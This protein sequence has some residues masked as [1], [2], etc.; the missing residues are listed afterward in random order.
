[1]LI[2]NLCFHSKFTLNKIKVLSLINTLVSKYTLSSSYF[3]FQTECNHNGIILNLSSSSA[4]APVPLL[5]IYSATKVY[6]DF[7]SLGLL[8]EKSYNRMTMQSIQ[9]YYVSTNMSNNMK[10]NFFVPTSDN[11]VRQQLATVG[12]QIQTSGYFTQRILNFIF[13]SMKYGAIFL[14]FEGIFIIKLKMIFIRNRI[15]KKICLC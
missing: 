8:Q 14:G 9:P 5:T 4:I 13:I 7:I 10:T 12:Q 2:A 11:Y 6:I 3:L 15:F 1:M